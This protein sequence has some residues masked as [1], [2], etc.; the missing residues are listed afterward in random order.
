MSKMDIALKKAMTPEFRVSFPAVFK[1]KAFKDQDPKY[2]VVMLFDKKTDISALK[3]A[4]ANAMLEKWPEAKD[5]EKR[6]KLKLKM[7]FR[8][9]DEKEDTQGYK[10]CI[11]V[12]ASSKTRP[13]LVNGKREPI[14]DEEEFYPGC[15]ARATLIAFAYDTAGNRGVS[16][17]LQNVQ[18][19]RDGES[20]SGR[21]RAED[22]F[23]EISD[24]SDDEDSYG[25][26]GD[27]DDDLGDIA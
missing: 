27:D 14:I 22:E 1:P 20:L 25:A 5:P 10:G 13:G 15:Y 24:G 23:D 6:K 11:F 26:G 8:D 18:K 16:F 4:A 21:K 12:S 2:S 3:K 17:S 19:I 7:P 9:G